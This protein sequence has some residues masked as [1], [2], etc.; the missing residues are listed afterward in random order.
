MEIVRQR[1]K[2]L[3]AWILTLV[4]CVGMW[5]GNVQA[6]GEDGGDGA[7][8][9]PEVMSTEVPP[10]EVPPTEAEPTEGG[11]E[12]AE[13]AVASETGDG[14]MPVANTEVRL[15]YSDNDNDGVINITYTIGDSIE[16]LNE[17]NEITIPT[18]TKSFTLNDE[19]AEN[20]KYKHNL[21]SWTIERSGDKAIT[22]SGN[23]ITVGEENWSADGNILT[24]NWERII[25]VYCN[26][27]FIGIL[28]ECDETAALPLP[29]I[30]GSGEEICFE[31]MFLE[32]EAPKESDEGAVLVINN[33]ELSANY[34]LVNQM[35]SRQYLSKSY[36]SKTV[37]ES[38]NFRLIPQMD[39]VLGPGIWKVGGDGYSYIGGQTFYVPSEEA[40]AYEL[41]GE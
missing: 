7:P 21:I 11:D 36:T 38:G 28:R 30:N 17:G 41:Q 15:A 8:T 37:P 40:Y 14:T 33:S 12:S 20:Y 18:G 5:Q 3:L 39:Y 19:Y 26:D 10:A 22:G 2:R 35:L 27:S 13:P 4:L 23:T 31:G 32:W 24:V 1:K 25:E 29:D 9:S 16:K 34:N 6:E